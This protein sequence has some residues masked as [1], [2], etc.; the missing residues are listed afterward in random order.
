MFSRV[1]AEA[2]GFGMTVVEEFSKADTPWGGYVRISEDSLPAFF[3]AYWKGI[4]VP[5]PAP[6]LKLDPKLL[7]VAPG[8]RLSLQFHHRRSEHWRVVAGPVCIVTG[9][10]K[11]TLEDKSYA[12]GDVLRIPC[13]RMHRLVGLDGWGLVAEIW[14][15]T[16]PANP[17]GEADIVR[18]EDD[19]GR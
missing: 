9:D 15:H 11:E 4:E 1:L 16:D 3:E 5:Q 19:F 8:A 7:L 17:S 14:Q 2:R 6:G 18:V 13:G 12:P 10:S